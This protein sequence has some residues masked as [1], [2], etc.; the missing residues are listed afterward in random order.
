MLFDFVAI[1]LIAVHYYVH[2]RRIGYV[3]LESAEYKIQN[4]DLLEEVDGA[5]KLI[6]LVETGRVTCTHQHKANFIT[7]RLPLLE[8]SKFL[9]NCTMTS[10]SLLDATWLGRRTMLVFNDFLGLSASLSFLK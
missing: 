2:P 4:S 6:L 10:F 8:D 1:H 5:Q 9:P 7:S 3:F